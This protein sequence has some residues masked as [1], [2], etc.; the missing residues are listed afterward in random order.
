[1]LHACKIF[2]SG[3]V[4]ARKLALPNKPTVARFDA[5]AEDAGAAASESEE[6]DDVN[7]DL[8]SNACGFNKQSMNVD[9][10]SVGAQ[11]PLIHRRVFHRRRPPPTGCSTPPGW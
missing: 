7:A 4:R 6:V 8:M 5:R 3:S 11:A 1:M 9:L 2:F 10:M